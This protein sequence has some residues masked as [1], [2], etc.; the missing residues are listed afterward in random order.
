MSNITAPPWPPTNFY[1]AKSVR[2]AN[3][4]QLDIFGHPLPNDL[5]TSG[6]TAPYSFVNQ[7][8]L[9]DVSSLSENH[10][11]IV[12]GYV[13]PNQIS[14]SATYTASWYRDR[15]GLLIFRKSYTLSSP[16]S[17]Q[18]WAPGSSSAW[19]IGWLSEDVQTNTPQY[20]EIQENGDYHVVLS[21][22]GGESFSRTI[23]FAV[24]GIPASTIIRAIGTTNCD[25][26]VRVSNYFDSSNYIRVGV[27]TQPFSDGQSS[28]PNG[29]VGYVNAPSSNA[30]CAAEGTATGLSP[31][32]TYTLYGFAQSASGQYFST[33]TV[34]F[35]TEAIPPPI[36][37]SPVDFSSRIDG[38]FNLFWGTS[39]AQN[40]G[41]L[42]YQLEYK[43]SYDTSWS[44]RTSVTTTLR[45]S[46]LQYGVTY[47]F[48]VMV[49]EVTDTGSKYSDYTAVSSWTTAPKTPSISVG[50]SG[51]DYVNIYASI[52]TPQGNY[53]EILVDRYDQ[54]MYYIDTKSTTS[55]GYVTWSGIGGKFSFVARSKFYINGINL[56][57]I[58]NSNT[59]TVTISARPA[60]Y[61]WST[62]KV[63]GGNVN[64]SA[65]EWNALAA[66]INDFRRYKGLSDY[67]FTTIYEGADIAAW[68]FNQA[69]S[70]F[71]G[72]SPPTSP[73]S[74]KSSG[75]DIYASYFNGL[76]NA[77]N[78]IQ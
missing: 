65:T 16:P 64:V 68:V 70:S 35:K 75:Q 73:P 17:G 31:N 13:S 21:A 3:G 71:S 25:Y 76:V 47:D 49:Y 61:S 52:A 55:G 72:L 30:G 50:S 44:E 24:K 5:S 8:T 7:T 2:G 59:L 38:G 57:S 34:T 66:R 46:G 51:A 15:D 74:S 28:A 20:K 39:T 22:S 63:S 12:I 53:D 4:A 41:S 18:S 19:W 32:T 33:G 48:R 14:S 78:S 58:N 40:G 36:P 26:T 54:N 45:L 56:Y 62:P 67:S 69:V 27:C 10:E 37:S 60:D 29:I 11:V 43:P 1:A 77:L 9:F 42:V 23:E 6:L